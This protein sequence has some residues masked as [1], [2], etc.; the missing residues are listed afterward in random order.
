MPDT[1]TYPIV[2]AFYR[3]PAKAILAVLPIGTRL[4]LRADPCGQSTGSSHNDETAVAVW[5]ATSDF[6]ERSASAFDNEGGAFGYDTERLRESSE[7]HVGYIPAGL[8]ARRRTA[9]MCD[10]GQDVAGEFTCNAAGSPL[11]R[12]EH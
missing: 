1:H 6:P 12:F 8:A 2:G 10:D 11:V 7:W 5:L 4:W 3:P 9:G